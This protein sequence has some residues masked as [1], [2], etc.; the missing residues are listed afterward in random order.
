[1]SQNREKLIDLLEDI[2]GNKWV[3]IEREFQ[4]SY[5]KDETPLP[6]L[7]SAANDLILVKPF[8]TKQVSK[9]L[10]IANKEKITVFP[11][12]GRTGL[13]GGSVPT[14]SGIILSLE[15]MNNIEF[16]K[17]NSMAIVEAGT[18]LGSFIEVSKRAGFFFPLHPGDEGAQIGGLISTNAGGVRAIKYGVMRNYVYGLEVVLPTGEI[19]N[20]GGKLLKNNTGYNLMQLI[21]GSEGTLCVITRA[22]IKLYP[23]CRYSSTMIVPFGNRYNAILSVNKILR[24]GII[25]LGV[26]YIELRDINKAA[27]HINERWPVQEGNFQLLILLNATTDNELLFAYEKISEILPE[28]NPN[29]YFLAETNKEEEMILRIR[30]SLYTSMKSRIID[31]LDLTVPSNHLLDLISAVEKTAFKNHIDLPIYGHVGDGNLH[32]HILK[33]ENTN[34]KKIEK[35]KKELYKVASNLGGVPTGE[36]GIGK[37][38][39][40]EIKK[41]LSEK[42]MYLMSKIKENFDPNNILNPGKI[43]S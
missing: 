23:E 3:I 42:E 38:R 33:E 43:L 6:M 16:D 13:V 36:H 40:E 26:E 35:I 39:T 31:I 28:Y 5:L 20:L 2:V 9:I 37:I 21:I 7:P 34:Q 1:M 25:P 14:E 17:E 4:S 30:S 41:A 8:S 18:T 10:E 22:V 12:G 24:S 29:D 19:L 11:V 15:R 32:V 27:K